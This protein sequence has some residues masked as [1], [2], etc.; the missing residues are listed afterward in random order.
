M[1]C[2]SIG[3]A[4]HFRT[5][6]GRSREVFT[7]DSVGINPV[8][9][10][11]AGAIFIIPSVGPG[12]FA[13]RISATYSRA[14]N[15][16]CVTTV[17]GNGRRCGLRSLIYTSHGSTL[18]R[19]EREVFLGN[20]INIIPSSCLT[21]AIGVYVRIG[22]CT[23]AVGNIVHRTCTRKHT[24]QSFIAFGFGSRDGGRCC[25]SSQ[26]F[27]RLGSLNTGSIYDRRCGRID[28]VG[29]H[30]FI[31]KVCTI[32]IE[33]GVLA[34]AGTVGNIVGYRRC[35]SIQ[36]LAANIFHQRQC[37]RCYSSRQ[38]FHFSSSSYCRTHLCR[39]RCTVHMIGEGP[40][41]GMIVAIG[42]G[43]HIRH[44]AF[45][46]HCGR[47][48]GQRVCAGNILTASVGS[49]RHHARVKFVRFYLGSGN[50]FNRFLIRASRGGDIVFQLHNHIGS[51]GVYTTVT[52]RITY[53]V[54]IGLA[55]RCGRDRGR[56]GIGKVCRSDHTA[57]INFSSI[58]LPS[59]HSVGIVH[60]GEGGGKF[61]RYYIRTYCHISKCDGRHRVSVHIHCHLNGGR[62][63][64]TDT[65][66]RGHCIGKCH[67]TRG[68]VHQVFTMD[69]GFICSRSASV[70]NSSSNRLCRKAPLVIGGTRC[71]AGRGHH[72]GTA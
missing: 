27:H 6:S 63:T 29:K 40:G 45:A 10:E 5:G 55:T 62:R 26:A 35:R 65:I 4:I 57:V 71:I 28:R 68:G 49:G 19:R 72:E 16:K 42:I 48:S 2:D 38:T 30:P 8:V 1:R 43:V 24:C 34:G 52:V 25:G 47:R 60:I 44:I 21:G 70:L 54:R 51:L 50:A 14:G 58:E 69:K 36:C 66:S 61:F 33:V 46:F 64:H 53:R 59:N 7:L 32:L 39:S 22:T 18:V 56:I 12:A 13:V 67:R 37:G 23:F 31:F 17:V 15:G 3:N 11:L 41:F 20:S 9:G